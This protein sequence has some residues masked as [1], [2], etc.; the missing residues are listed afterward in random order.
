MLQGQDVPAVDVAVVCCKEELSVIMDTVKAAL[1]TDYPSD[2]L[3]IIVSDDG[4]QQ[5][6]EEGVRLLEKQYPGMQL[7][8]TARTKTSENSH[9]AGNLNHVLE[10]T[11]KLPGSHAQFIAGLDAD[12]IPERRWLRAQLPH[13]LLDTRMAF[14]CPP[15]CFYN[16]PTDDPISQSLFAFHRFEE[17]VKD[18]AG[19]AWCTGS[20][21]VMRRAALAEI[22]GFPTESLTEDLLCG[23]LMLGR[24]ASTP[25]HTLQRTK[26]FQVGDRL[27]CRR[28]YSGVWYRPRTTGISGNELAG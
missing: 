13:L 1:C 5:C 23:K 21:W 17:I 3:R 9:K 22:G 16:V 19:I 12:M 24:G 18:T 28:H 14:T 25:K 6:V 10:Y 7:F 11:A 8:Y 15:P 27:M 4:A 26:D 20:G 2:R